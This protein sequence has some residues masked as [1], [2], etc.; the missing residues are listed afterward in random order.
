[1]KKNNHRIFFAVKTKKR[2]KK[3]PFACA[4]VSLLLLEQRR[5]TRNILLFPHPYSFCCW[6]KKGIQEVSLCL[7]IRI[8]FAV[9]TKQVSLRKE[10]SPFEGILA[11]FQQRKEYGC[12]SKGILLVSLFCSNNKRNTDAETKG[13]FLYP[14]FVLTTKGIQMRKQRDTSCISSLF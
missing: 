1:M 4:F 3:Y 2:Y 13:Y 5:D 14:F 6:N 10:T 8:L 12:A 7:R 11:L 9:G